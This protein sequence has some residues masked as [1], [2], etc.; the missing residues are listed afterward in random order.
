MAI[1]YFNLF[2][3]LGSWLY[4]HL[5]KRL[6]LNILIIN[7]NPLSV[8]LFKSYLRNIAFSLTPIWKFNLFIF[9]NGIDIWSIDCLAIFVIIN[10]NLIINFFLFL[11]VS[12]FN[13]FLS[14][15]F[16]LSH[17]VNLSYLGVNFMED[18][19]NIDWSNCY[20]EFGITKA[21]VILEIN[22]T[23]PRSKDKH[24]VSL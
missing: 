10:L 18:S 13:F 21:H 23:Y 12:L 14:F 17:F 6:T 5:F 19:K 1:R 4:L 16:Q 3:F 11:L 20:Q 24:Q 8:A 15:V 9:L 2:L 7:F 22:I